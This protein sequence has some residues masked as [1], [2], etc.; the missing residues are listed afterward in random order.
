MNRQ[1]LFWHLPAL[2]FSRKHQVVQCPSCGL[3]YKVTQKRQLL[4]LVTSKS[5]AVSVSPVTRFWCM[6]WAIISVGF[7]VGES[8]SRPSPL[9]TVPCSS[10]HKFNRAGTLELEYFRYFQFNPSIQYAP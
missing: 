9:H 7:L 5:S 1:K 2:P 3:C 10:R 6:F 4:S 8:S